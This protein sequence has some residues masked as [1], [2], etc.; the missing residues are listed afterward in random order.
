MI[1]SI[2]LLISSS[3]LLNISDKNSSYYTFSAITCAI[4]GICIC[5]N[6]VV[7]TYV[8]TKE[9]KEPKKIK[10]SK[11]QS[12]ESEKKLDIELVPDEITTYW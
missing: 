7:M 5:I 8:Q 6:S 10:E 1:L 2:L 4:G 11:T 12:T 9:S 3:I